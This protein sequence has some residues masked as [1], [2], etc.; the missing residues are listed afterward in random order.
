MVLKSS[1]SDHDLVYITLKLKK[2]HSKPVYI[3]T[4]SYKHYKADAF[5]GDV[6]KAPWSIVVVFSDVED[7]LASHAGVFRG[8]RISS[9]GREE[10]RAPLKTPAWEAKDKLHVFNLHFSYILDHHY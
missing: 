1:I 6:S 5:H 10:I 2:E 7:K 3:T 9:V 8:A 4:R